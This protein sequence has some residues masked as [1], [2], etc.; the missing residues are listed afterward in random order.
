MPNDIKVR[1]EKAIAEKVFPGCVLGIVRKNGEREIFPFGRFTYEPNSPAV[2]EDTIYDMASVTKSIPV[3]SLALTLIGEGRMRAT[4]TV[5]KYLPE[6][7]NDY[8]ATVED[9]LTYRVKGTRLST[10][11]DKTPDEVL[12]IV[13]KNGFDGPPEKP[14][15]T[16]LPAFLL[17]LVVE[18]WFD[19]SLVNIAE[20]YFFMPLRMMDTNFFPPDIS[21]IVPTEVVDGVEIRGIVHDES[22]RVFAR[23]HRAVGH[24][25]LFS[26]APDILNFLES[27][28]QGK[29]Q[30]IVE[31]ARRG[32]GW[33]LNQQW[34][35]GKHSGEHTFGKTGFTGTSVVCD[36]E[37]GIAF[38]ILSNRTYPKRPPDAASI[39]SAINPFRADIAD[40]L[41]H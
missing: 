40:I 5:V 38:V 14:E 11:H 3:A 16:N 41:M 36:I 28:L 9:L 7:K 2:R 34:F 20:G 23:A 33:Q 31:G 29:Y 1:V 30:N 8:G 12:N 25:G 35:M 18:R 17:G 24:A 21:R 32:L 10:L 39:P 13:F 22:A 37:R 6:L 15:Y 26:T 19:D 4:D 27:L